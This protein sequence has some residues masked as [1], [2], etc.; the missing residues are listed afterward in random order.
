MA[1]HVDYWDNLGWKDAFSNSDYTSRQ[2]EY[3]AWLNLQSIYT[4]QLVVNGKSEFVGS[5]ETKI[6]ASITQ[7]LA[8]NGRA[9]LFIQSKRD[10]NKLILNC[11]FSGATNRSRLVIALIQKSAKTKVERGENSGRLLS[12][13][14]IV[15]SLQ[16]ENINS[17][18]KTTTKITLPKDFNSQ[19]W[20]VIALIQDSNGGIQAAS[21]IKL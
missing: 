13:V 20:E 1:F 9:E 16:S 21:R 18:G 6:R 10:D 5:D 7:A 15:R 3:G 2:K 12:H 8:V 17:D 11:Q 14:Q 4:P 19:N